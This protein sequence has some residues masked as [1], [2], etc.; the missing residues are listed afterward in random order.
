MSFTR[1]KQYKRV[2]ILLPIKP[3]TRKAF[4]AI[5]KKLCD[6][7]GGITYSKPHIPSE[8][9]GIWLDPLTGN[10]IND[11]HISLLIDVDSSN[12]INVDKYFSQLKKNLEKSLDENLIWIL[13]QNAVRIA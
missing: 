7:F 9:K 6:D 1:L 13:Y 5:V 10:I 4:K 2:N 12:G 8:V 3:E 11:H